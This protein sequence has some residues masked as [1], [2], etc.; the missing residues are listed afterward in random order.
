MR[1]ITCPSTAIHGAIQDG[2]PI[3][4]G[5]NLVKVQRN[6][7]VRIFWGLYDYSISLGFGKRIANR[8]IN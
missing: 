2:F 1:I 5:H 6:K 4:A 3:K 7:G 8:L